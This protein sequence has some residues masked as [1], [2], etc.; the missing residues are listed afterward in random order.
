[1]IYCLD[2]H[3]SRAAAEA[4][5]VSPNFR[6]L[7]LNYACVSFTHFACLQ[8]FDNTQTMLESGQSVSV[9]L[10]C[11]SPTDRRR[12]LK[13][14][15]RQPTVGLHMHDSFQDFLSSARLECTNV[16]QETTIERFSWISTKVIKIKREDLS[17]LPLM[18]LASTSM[19]R[20]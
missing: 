16:F 2:I 17:L 20:W 15:H 19:M 6:I 13:K 1:M 11:E 5:R 9:S 4:R 3:L 8:F 12:C 18:C 14:K 7:V 10:Q